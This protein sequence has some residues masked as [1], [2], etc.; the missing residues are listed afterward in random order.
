MKDVSL[1]LPPGDGVEPEVERI[2]RLV[3]HA[4]PARQRRGKQFLPRQAITMV[5]LTSEGHR[6]DITSHVRGDR[7]VF[8]EI[9]YRET[10]LR[11]FHTQRGHRNPAPTYKPVPGPHVH[12]PSKKYPL[13][14]KGNSYAYC[15][16]GDWVE[17]AFEGIQALCDEVEFIIQAGEPPSDW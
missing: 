8:T 17:T 10:T 11:K 13:E 3:V 7:N 16:D 5:A 2:L 12:F 1:L 4:Y 9:N 6:L 14:Y 15:V